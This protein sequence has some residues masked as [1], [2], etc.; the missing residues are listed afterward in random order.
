VILLRQ[1]QMPTPKIQQAATKILHRSAMATS[2]VI[3][4]PPVLPITRT[5]LPVRTPPASLALETNPNAHIR[6]LAPEAFLSPNPP[7]HVNSADGTVFILDISGSM[8]E[9]YAGSTRLAF[10]RASLVRRIRA[11]K[12]GTPFAITLYAERAC[13]SGPLVP[14]NDSTRDAAVRYLN[15]DVDCGGGTNLPAALA[16]AQQLDPGTLV[17]ATDGDL[18][19]TAFHLAAQARQLL[20]PQEHCP[21]LTVIGIAPRPDTGAERLLQGLADEQGGTYCGE[22]NAAPELISS[23]SNVAREPSPNR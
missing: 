1:E 12:D 11:L 19:I 21:S 17:L 9:S 23:T 22:Q 7:P 3:P 15:R 10:A 18:N 20:G 6:P 2:T 13:T 16:S 8:Y 14:A 4:V 5:E